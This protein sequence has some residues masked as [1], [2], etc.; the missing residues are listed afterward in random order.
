[1]IG[2]GPLTAPHLGNDFKPAE[3][4]GLVLADPHLHAVLLELFTDV[5][6]GS[7]FGRPTPGW[8]LVRQDREAM[9]ASTSAAC[10]LRSL[11]SK[12]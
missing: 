10:S 2:I 1:M 5:A 11:P 3:A 4:A 7:R 9:S 12:S 6:V 8:R